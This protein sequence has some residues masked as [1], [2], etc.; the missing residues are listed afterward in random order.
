MARPLNPMT[1]VWGMVTRGTKSAGVQGPEH[2]I[3][4]ADALTYTTVFADIVPPRS[5]AKVHRASKRHHH[6]RSHHR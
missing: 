4:V 5:H 6:R 2:A 3:G 1:N